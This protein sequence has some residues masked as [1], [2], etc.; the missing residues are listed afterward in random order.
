MVASIGTTYYDTIDAAVAAVKTGETIKLEAD[1]AADEITVEASKTFTIDLNGKNFT[2]RITCAGNLTITDASTTEPEQTG[3]VLGDITTKDGGKVTVDAGHYSCDPVAFIAVDSQGMGKGVGESDNTGKARGYAVM[4]L[5]SQVAY[6]PILQTE[7]NE[8][9]ISD[10]ISAEDKAVLQSEITKVSVSGVA[11]NVTAEARA[12]I[13]SDSGI[14][15][16]TQPKGSI[17]VISINIEVEAVASQIVEAGNNHF[18]KFALT[19]TAKVIV[20]KPDATA[21]TMVASDIKTVAFDNSYLSGGDIE[22]KLPDGGG[23]FEPAE[24]VH[25]SK[26]DD[27]IIDVFHR[28]GPKTFTYDTNTN[29]VRLSISEFSYLT[30]EETRNYVNINYID[31]VSGQTYYQGVALNDAANDATV[32][33]E[34]N[35]F[36]RVGYTF[37]N[38]NLRADGTATSYSDGSDITL[39]SNEG[40]QILFAQ[41]SANSYNVEFVANGGVGV[42]ADQT[43][44]YDSPAALSANAFVYDGYEFAGWAT[45]PEGG[46]VYTDGQVV[47]NLASEQGDVVTLYAKWTNVEKGAVKVSDTESAY[48]NDNATFDDDEDEWCCDNDEDFNIIPFVVGGLG[49]A[50]V[51]ALI[52]FLIKRRKKDDDNQQK[53]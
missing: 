1:A 17:V 11:E 15:P 42:M 37:A 7:C 28:T 23:M 34:A 41:W 32:T 25:T 43:M 44:V 27:S 53:K 26:A 35:K 9:K 49:L 47:S 5:Q 18:I 38:W 45:S 3:G 19:P 13:I 31:P 29:V 14:N 20:Y 33:L 40:D 36:S 48:A 50:L 52:I 39:K 21:G 10:E 8:L 51:A 6:V 24:I 4:I 46:V 2:G 16:S 12:Q 22:I 30:V